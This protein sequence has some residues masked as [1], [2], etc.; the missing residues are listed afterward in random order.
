MRLSI[1]VIMVASLSQAYAATEYEYPELLVTPRAS[2][3][4]EME[5]R[6]EAAAKWTRMVPLQVSALSTFAAG[7]LQ[8][9]NVNLSRDSGEY[10]PWVGLGVGGGW[11]AVTAA[12][13]AMYQP[14]ASGVAEVKA[15]QGNGKREQ[16][17][18]ERMAEEAIDAAAALGRRLMWL[19]VATNF[20]ASAYMLSKAETSSMAQVADGVAM[21]LALTPLLF[22]SRWQDVAAEQRDY[23]KKIY[24]PI[25]SG[26][27]LPTAD[28][29]VVPG[30]TLSFMF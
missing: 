7:V 24:G 27:F 2:E 6:K 8:F 14:Y 17:A 30:M 9:G 1:A 28:G 23:K 20:V 29:K 3:R 12:L 13:S 15:I 5:T 4:L 25:A 22:Q 26:G 21:A 19:S 16:L 11:L 10:S 18:R